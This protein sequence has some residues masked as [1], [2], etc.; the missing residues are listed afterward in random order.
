[1]VTRFT[2]KGIVALVFSCISGILGVSVI[3]WYGFADV[4]EGSFGP[5]L[6]PGSGTAGESG[7]L[8]SKGAREGDA[9][10]EAGSGSDN[11]GPPPAPSLPPSAG[12][13]ELRL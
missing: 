1:M 8:E 3:A 9:D 4:P 12:Q 6:G 10:G 5:V 7:V 13:N 11:N 2:T